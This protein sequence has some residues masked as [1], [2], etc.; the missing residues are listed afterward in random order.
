MDRPKVTQKSCDRRHCYKNIFNSKSSNQSA[1]LQHPDASGVFNFMLSA[2]LMSLIILT[3]EV[4]CLKSRYGKLTIEKETCRNSRLVPKLIDSYQSTGSFTVISAKP[5]QN[6]LG[7]IGT[8]MFMWDCIKSE[9]Q[10]LGT[11]SDRFL[12]GSCCYHNSTF[13]DIDIQKPNTPEATS[14]LPTTAATISHSQNDLGP[15]ATTSFIQSTSGLSDHLNS[16]LSQK[17]NYSNSVNNDTNLFES[18]SDISSQNWSQ[19]QQPTND[20]AI[21]VYNNLASSASLANNQDVLS[22]TTADSTSPHPTST[23]ASTTS[24]TTTT[25][26]TTMA[27]PQTTPQNFIQETTSSRPPASNSMSQHHHQ[28]TIASANHHYKPTISNLQ[29]QEQQHLIQQQQPQKPA[30]GSSWLSRPALSLA[31]AFIHSFKPFPYLN[32]TKLRPPTYRP[33]ATSNYRPQ[34]FRPVSSGQQKPAALIP[35]TNEILSSSSSD[36]NYNINNNTPFHSNT[37]AS[38]SLQTTANQTLDNNDHHVVNPTMTDRHRPIDKNSHPN[39]FNSQAISSGITDSLIQKQNHY[40]ILTNSNSSS[41]PIYNS[42]S[43]YSPT[44]SSPVSSIHYETFEPATTSTV[45]QSTQSNN[46]NYSSNLNNNGLITTAYHDFDNAKP[47][48]LLEQH[49]QNETVN[50]STY[51]LISSSS[52]ETPPTTNY[53]HTSPPVGQYSDNDKEILSSLWTD[54]QL[55]IQKTTPSAAPFSTTTIVSDISDVPASSTTAMSFSNIPVVSEQ[56]TTPTAAATTT[57]TTMHNSVTMP[58]MTTTTL[59]PKTF[60]GTSGVADSNKKGSG[61][62]GAIGHLGSTNKEVACGMT[63]SYPQTKVVGGKNAAFGAWP[64]QV[65]VRKVSFFGFSSTHRCGGAVISSEWIATAGHCVED[66]PLQSIRIRVGEYDFGSLS[67][68][69][70]FIERSAR[71]KVVHPKY[72]FYTYEN[73]L[74]LVQ[75]D[76]PIVFPPHI[77][78]ICLPP[79]NIDL[80]GRNATVTGWGRLNEGGTLPTILQEVRVPIVSNDKCKDMFLSA[81]RPEYIPDIFLCAGYEEGGRDSCQGDS[82]GPLQVK[83]DDGKWFLAGIIS[84]GIG[85][86]EQN[87]PGVCTRISRFKLWIQST[88]SSSS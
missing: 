74:A 4:D 69:F 10:H 11:C 79:D 84:W 34:H 42:S 17:S 21:N 67:E 33:F 63:A 65:S 45:L 54:Y 12:F 55:M 81:G 59:P 32:P 30:S 8:C 66:L 40:E 2:I 37:S 75:L 3:V 16:I 58:P 53:S 83:G 41:I 39:L 82:G 57:T 23:A 36:N 31:N 13:N 52:Y 73:D 24:T 48:I 27:Y 28:A 26:T 68:P 56:T 80:L 46:N 77:A 72:N 43:Y 9:G 49:P 85:C 44:S 86:A 5:C 20:T 15:I 7:Q 60:G 19:Q 14:F 25:T 71:R 6:A 38:I 87:L 76:Q 78:P 88:M 70:P 64:W 61:A 1:K 62:G 51:P 22:T 35:T 47:I 29:P 50:H 18:S